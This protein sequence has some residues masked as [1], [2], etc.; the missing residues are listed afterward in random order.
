M[1]LGCGLLFWDDCL[2]WIGL[3]R[4]RFNRRSCCRRSGWRLG[5]RRYSCPR[6]STRDFWREL[7]ARG[8]L[9]AISWGIRSLKRDDLL[10]MKE[11]TKLAFGA[12]G[13]SRPVG[14]G[15]CKLPS[16]ADMASV[17]SPAAATQR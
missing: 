2:R 7:L 15:G 8:V 4:L 13:L 17:L 1:R 12:C 5:G 9:Y 14:G 6:P 3:N 16:S 10:F 11:L